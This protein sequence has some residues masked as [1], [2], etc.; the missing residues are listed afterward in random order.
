MALPIAPARPR[1][2]PETPYSRQA[3]REWPD[4]NYANKTAGSAFTRDLPLA[5]RGETVLENRR[6]GSW[7]TG[8][9]QFVLGDGS[10]RGLRTNIDIV[11]LTWLT[12]RNDGR[13]PGDF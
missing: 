10:V 12:I 4:N 6:F 9:C 11:T 13:V 3:G 7:H 2:A 8:V 5:Q 1:S